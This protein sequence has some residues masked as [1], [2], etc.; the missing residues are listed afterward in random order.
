VAGGDLRGAR[1]RAA[2]RLAGIRADL[3]A[4]TAL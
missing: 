1:E 4:A 3:E 2:T